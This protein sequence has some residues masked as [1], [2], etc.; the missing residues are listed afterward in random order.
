MSN[1]HTLHVRFRPTAA[2]A[3]IKKAMGSLWKATNEIYHQL[4]PTDAVPLALGT[5]APRRALYLT[6]NLRTLELFAI[7]QPT[8]TAPLQVIQNITSFDHTPKWL[9]AQVVQQIINAASPPTIR[10]RPGQ[11]S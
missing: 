11:S 1:T 10:P 4:H 2:T 9:N 5:N 3:E 6:H 7:A 8:P